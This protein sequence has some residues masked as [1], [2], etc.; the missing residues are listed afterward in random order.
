MAK[1]LNSEVVGPCTALS[2]TR[3]CSIISATGKALHVFTKW[4]QDDSDENSGT[5]IS[6]SLSF[7]RR[8]PEYHPKF[9]TELL[10]HQEYEKVKKILIHLATILKEDEINFKKYP[11]LKLVK[12]SNDSIE[13]KK[14]PVK[15]T[16]LSKFSGITISYEDEDYS[17]D[18]ESDE[19]KPKKSK[20]DSDDDEK[21]LMP[22]P[23]AYKLLLSKLS[24]IVLPEINGLEQ[25]HLI[26]LINAYNTI[27]E[28]P[29]A[30]DE[31][32]SRYLISFRIF[33]NQSKNNPEVNLKYAH[34]AWAMQSTTQETLLSL[35]IPPGTTYTLD[36]MVNSGLIYWVQNPLLLVRK[37]CIYY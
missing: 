18:E 27:Q 13:Q 36:L 3:E 5:L 8:L 6:K 24:N 23:E 21:D 33:L 1:F 34:V 14:L 37:I 32:G 28:K 7:H 2:I 20:E 17:D 9:L 12:Q 35:S 22:F 11:L 10:M 16:L 4:A 19:E 30:L 31:P 29:D 25:L 26:A 15:D